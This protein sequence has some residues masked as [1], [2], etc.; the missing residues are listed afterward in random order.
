[1]EDK[2]VICERLCKTLQATDYAHDLVSLDYDYKTDL[3]TARF[4]SSDRL[5]QL[6]VSGDNGKTMI[7]NIMRY[8][9]R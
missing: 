4:S 3:V 2:Q 7:W 5:W 6:D 9:V 1:M 8:L